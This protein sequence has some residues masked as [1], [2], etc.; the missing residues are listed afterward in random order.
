MV[1]ELALMQGAASKSAVPEIPSPVPVAELER[2]EQPRER[3]RGL[4]DAGHPLAEA[5][6]GAEEWACYGRFAKGGCESGFADS[7][8]PGSLQ[9]YNCG[10]CDIDFCER[11]FTRLLRQQ[12]E[13]ARDRRVGP[14][15][16]LKLPANRGPGSTARPASSLLPGSAKSSSSPEPPTP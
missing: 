2:Q 8:Q 6:H 9:H 5:R 11:C 10:T 3:C 15:S 16:S 13:A 12:E 4:C 14:G 1:E 7:L